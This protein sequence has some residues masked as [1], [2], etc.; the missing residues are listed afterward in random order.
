MKCHLNYKQKQAVEDFLKTICTKQDNGM[1]EYASGYNDITAAKEAT[2]LLGVE[3]SHVIVR[4]IRTAELGK[5]YVRGPDIAPRKKPGAADESAA[6][7][8]A[9]LE[10]RFMAELEKCNGEIAKLKAELT[11]TMARL[12]IRVDETDKQN[13]HAKKREETNQ[14][15][16]VSLY[17]RI[18]T[19]EERV[20]VE[21]VPP[22][23]GNLPQTNGALTALGEQL[24]D[25]YGIKNSTE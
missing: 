17:A 22:K 10:A 24:R 19:V 3:V 14:Q 15:H 13:F 5:L 25:R 20:G 16:L 2:K 4:S 12:S 1:C 18:S 6:D 21:P 8:V 11:H 7:M 23:R 9:R